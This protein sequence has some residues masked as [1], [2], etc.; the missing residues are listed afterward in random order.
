MI[1]F[2]KSSAAGSQSRTFF[3]GI[4]NIARWYEH[5]SQFDDISAETDQIF[6]KNFTTDLSLDKKVITKFRKSSGSD[7]WTLDPG[8]IRLSG[9]IYA[10]IKCSC[11]VLADSRISSAQ[12]FFLSVSFCYR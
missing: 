11:F 12:Y 3:D 4:F 1:K 10:L 6:V 9:G 2:W 5:Y 8:R 7:V